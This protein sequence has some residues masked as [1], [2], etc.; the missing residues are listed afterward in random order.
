M[1]LISFFFLSCFL[2][3]LRAFI[4]YVFGGFLRGDFAK[5]ILISAEIH[6]YPEQF[7]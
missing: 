4:V 1:L 2:V 5:V 3:S 7:K 6:P